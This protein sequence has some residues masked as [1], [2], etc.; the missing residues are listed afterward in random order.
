M[1]HIGRSAEEIAA[2]RARYE[3]HQKRGLEFAPKAL[4][5]AEHAAGPCP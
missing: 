5:G 4:A 1:T 3:E 2:D